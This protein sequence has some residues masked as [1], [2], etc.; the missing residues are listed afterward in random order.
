[1]ADGAVKK[2]IECG[3]F[4]TFDDFTDGY[5]QLCALKQDPE[6]KKKQ[7]ELAA[8]QAIYDRAEEVAGSVIVSSTD[9][10]PGKT[11]G[12]YLGLVRGGTCRAKHA[13]RDIAAGLKNIVGGGDSWLHAANGGGSRGGTIPH[14]G[15]C[16]KA[17]G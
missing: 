2:C 9:S 12:D 4:N 17:R 16:C 8:Q 3:R 11:V 7:Q 6:Y 10:I 1:M 13:G 15:G 14:E 5:C